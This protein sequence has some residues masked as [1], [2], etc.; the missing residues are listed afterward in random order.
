MWTYR[1][2]RPLQPGETQQTAID[3]LKAE[4]G[5]VAVEPIPGVDCVN[6][7]L[8][9]RDVTDLPHATLLIEH[10]EALPGSTALCWIDE[11]GEIARHLVEDTAALHVAVAKA[12]EAAQAE[13]SARLRALFGAGGGGPFGSG[14]FGKGPQA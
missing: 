6:V 8:P 12:R 5:V 10:P 1:L 9:A 7:Y 13:G 4:P 3:R 2:I 11:G 14:G